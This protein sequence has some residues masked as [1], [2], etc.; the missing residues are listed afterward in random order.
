MKH[1][2]APSLASGVIESVPTIKQ[3]IETMINEAGEIIDEFRQWGML[4]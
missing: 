4:D 2:L 3:F 1:G